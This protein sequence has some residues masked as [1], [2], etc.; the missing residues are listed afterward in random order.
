M[1][2]ST[3]TASINID[4]GT[5]VPEKLKD[6]AIVEALCEIRFDCSEVPER[7]IGRLSDH[8]EWTAFSIERLP[9]SDIP[10]PVRA[11]DATLKFQPVLQLRSDDGSYLIKIGSNVISYHNLGAYCGWP[12]FQPRLNELFSFLFSELDNVSIT[13]LGFRYI[14]A[15]TSERHHITSVADLNLRLNVADTPLVGPINLNFGTQYSDK[16]LAMTRIASIDFVQGELPEG[17]AAVIDVDVFTPQDFT[18]T[19]PEEGSS[20]VSDAHT[21][22]KHAFFRLIPPN[23][24]KELEEG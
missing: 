9:V 23:I 12:Q 22:E 8:E 21:Y 16:H 2:S 20:W 4:D 1:T 10:A 13:R 14:N 18:A 7:V 11:Q 17:V 15:L 19:N 6:D 24:L 5:H 3:G